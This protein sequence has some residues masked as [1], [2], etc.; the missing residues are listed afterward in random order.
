MVVKK[1]LTR[2]TK[3]DKDISEYLL[4]LFDCKDIALKDVENLLKRSHAYVYNR[5]R[6]IESFT[7]TD[8]SK[9][10]KLLG[11]TTIFSFFNGLQEFTD[12]AHK[13]VEQ[14]EH[15]T[16]SDFKEETLYDINDDTST[17]NTSKIQLAAHH[18]KNKR[19]EQELDDFGA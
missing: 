17:L 16:I 3:I 7:I 12:T 8:L 1:E 14:T 18:D 2:A 11:F 9:I 19:A 10:A 6:G 4:D 15:Y 5:T 13:T